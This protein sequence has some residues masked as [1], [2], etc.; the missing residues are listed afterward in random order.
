M[1]LLTSRV[2]RE[3]IAQLGTWLAAGREVAPR[4]AAAPLTE[5]AEAGRRR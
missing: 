5:E 4:M 2:L 1:R 3:V